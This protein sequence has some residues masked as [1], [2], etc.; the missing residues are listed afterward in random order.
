MRKILRQGLDDLLVVLREFLNPAVSRSGL[1]RCLRRHG[2]G[3]LRDLE[4]TPDWPVHKPFKAYDHDYFHPVQ[5]LKAWQKQHP[6][7]FKKR[8]CNRPGLDI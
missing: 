4:P 8:V 5:S 3:S 1:D 6:E 2:V 7:L